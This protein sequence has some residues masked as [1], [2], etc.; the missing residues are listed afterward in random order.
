MSRKIVVCGYPIKGKPALA[1]ILYEEE[2]PV[3]IALTGNKDENLLGSIFVGKVEKVDPGLSAA[4]VQIGKDRT[5]YLALSG[6]QLSG[7]KQAVKA[8]DELLVQVEKEAIKQK[9]PRLTTNLSLAGRYLVFT[10]EHKGINYSRKLS[11]GQKAELKATLETVEPDSCP[12]G[13]IIRTNAV[14][15]EKAELQSE[16]R[17]LEAEMT[18]IL[19]T[20]K[21]R[22][23]YFCLYTG[24]KEWIRMLRQC[25]FRG[26][27]RIVTDSPEVFADIR[28]YMEAH[29][30]AMTEVPSR[31]RRKEMETSLDF[32]LGNGAAVRLDLYADSM[33]SLYKLYNMTTLMDTLLGRQV[34]LPSGGFLVIEQTEAFAAIDVNTGRADSGKSRE[35]L[36]LRIN[37]EA[38]AEAARQIRLRQLSGTILIDFINMSDPA[39]E[40][41]LGE[42]LQ[43]NL[44]GDPLGARV[45]DFTAL[46]I[47]EVTRTKQVRSL[48]E[49]VDAILAVDT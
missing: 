21:S 43:A 34:H 28:S 31:A 12:Y 14:E 36:A 44:S 37:R 19:S 42:Y 3:E 20:G 18:R 30:E 26:L 13:V 1:S 7:R 4:F 2:K 49:Q 10:S 27:D 9:L 40:K 5:G 23:C 32:T 16:W 29:A 11:A 24:Q 6:V 38:A 39:E 46:H 48:R 41:A 45:I 35:K 25:A 47:C 17:E 33:I 8:G 22:T 15:A